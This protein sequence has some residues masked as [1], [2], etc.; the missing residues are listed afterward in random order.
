[1]GKKEA[2][3]EA[4]FSPLFALLGKT[5]L[6]DSVHKMVTLHSCN[7]QNLLRGFKLIYLK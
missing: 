3:N 7:D 1:M 4:I 6:M 5:E 2:F